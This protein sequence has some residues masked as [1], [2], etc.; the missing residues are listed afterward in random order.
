MIT[1][2]HLYKEGVWSRVT[3]CSLCLLFLLFHFPLTSNAQSQNKKPPIGTTN[4]EIYRYTQGSSVSYGDKIPNV[5]NVKVETISKKTG[6]TLDTKRY[7]DEE[8]EL[9]R[10]EKEELEV[11]KVAKSKEDEKNKDVLGKYSSLKD[12]EARKKYE[13]GKISEV[14]QKDIT[15]QV[16]L[17][18]QKATLDRE[19]NRNPD[20]KKRLEIEYRMLEKDLEKVKANIELNKSMYF[21]RST[22]FDS[23]KERY[24]KILEDAKNKE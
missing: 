6:I 2:K 1:N 16:T 5:G 9:Q 10:K 19:I 23:D 3:L 8:L 12:I 17:E 24:I 20:N 15:A 18:D 22:M 14:I 4:S 13:L 21:E 11:R 7:S